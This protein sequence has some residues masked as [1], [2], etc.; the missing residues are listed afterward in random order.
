MCCLFLKVISTCVFIGYLFLKAI[1]LMCIFR[2]SVLNGDFLMCIIGCLFLKVISSCVFSGY[3]FLKVISSCVFIGCL[4]LKV[5]I[6]MC[7][8]RLS[9]FKGDYPH[10]YL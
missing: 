5:I 7:I 10:V 1:I 2:L 6:L 8:F 4:F 3:L 9:I